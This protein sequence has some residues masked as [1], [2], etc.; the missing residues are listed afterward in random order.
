MSKFSSKVY[1]KYGIAG[2]G[3]TIPDAKLDWQRQFDMALNPEV[4]FVQLV[5]YDNVIAIVCRTPSGWESEILNDDSFNR[6][7][8]CSSL[9]PDT[10]TKEAV[11]TAARAH[12]A[13]LAYVD[14][15][16]DETPYIEFIADETAAK[17]FLSHNA[18]QRKYQELVKN[19]CP[20]DQAHQRTCEEMWKND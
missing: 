15:T 4:G 1:E 5:R 14:Y 7:I 3:K 17:Q 8:R 11:L 16:A 6:P 9:Y 12:V 18:W 19:G 20:L 13:S 2:T 10:I